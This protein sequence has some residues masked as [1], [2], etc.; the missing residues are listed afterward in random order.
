MNSP[1]NRRGGRFN[2]QNRRRRDYSANSIDS[3]V[4]LPYVIGFF[5]QVEV[6]MLV[7]TGSAVTIINE[8]VW[9][10]L[11]SN[12]PLDKVPFSVKSNQ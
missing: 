10:L 11:K 7:D 6:P 1:Q 9:K 2:N 4:T 5:N 8:D 3:P 12:E